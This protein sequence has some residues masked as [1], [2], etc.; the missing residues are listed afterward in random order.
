MSRTAE[1]WRAQRYSDAVGWSSL[2]PADREEP[3]VHE[4]GDEDDAGDYPE[5]VAEGPEDDE[6]DG[7]HRAECV[8]RAGGTDPA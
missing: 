3:A 4:P 7:A 5:E 8:G 6:L 1:T 2:M